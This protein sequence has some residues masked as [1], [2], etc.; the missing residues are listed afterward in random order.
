M[1]TDD[2]DAAY[3]RLQVKLLAGMAVGAIAATASE[4]VELLDGPEATGI[5]LSALTILGWSYAAWAL[6]RNSIASQRG[7][8][9]ALEND[10]LYTSFRASS[11]TTGFGAMLITQIIFLVGG[12]V[13]AKFS[14]IELSVSF[15][16]AT[17]I[18]IGLI[19]ALSRFVYLSR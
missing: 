3:L 4:L 9:S 14:Q 19:A 7:D 8:F 2:T 1:K 15:A 10:E 6:M 13:L 16:A 17:S 5:L 11:F 18:S 12:D